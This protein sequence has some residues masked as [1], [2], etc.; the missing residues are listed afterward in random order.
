[1]FVDFRD[2]QLAGERFVYDLTDLVRQ[3]G[4]PAFEPMLDGRTVTPKT[5]GSASTGTPERGLAG[6]TRV[7]HPRRHD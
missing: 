5:G 1:V 6:G 7:G 3:L 4:E 2:G